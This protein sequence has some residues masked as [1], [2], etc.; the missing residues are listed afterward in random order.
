[1]ISLF[2]LKEIEPIRPGWSYFAIGRQP[3]SVPGHE[4]TMLRYGDF[5]VT[6]ALYRQTADTVFKL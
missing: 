6:I 1:V 4:N 3:I 5:S 2:E